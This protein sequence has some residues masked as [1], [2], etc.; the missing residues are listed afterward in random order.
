MRK[1]I[2]SL[3]FVLFAGFAF[4]QSPLYV[5]TS[6]LNVGVGL[7]NSGIPLYIGF[8][9]SFARDFTFGAELSYRGYNEKWNDR[10]WDHDIFGISGNINYHFNSLLGIS[11]RWDVYAGLNAGVYIW[12][13]P[14]DYYGNRTTGLGLGGQVGVRYYFTN[15]VGLNLEYGGG[16]AFS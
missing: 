3:S 2:I 4:S 8:D 7:S 1:L 6:Q 9:K 13:S 16:N 12:T 5:G 14:I 15:K 10:Y 11:P